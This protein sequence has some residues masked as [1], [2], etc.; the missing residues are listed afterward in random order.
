MSHKVRI[1]YRKQRR[2]W[3]GEYWLN[4]KRYAKGF[5]NK[6]EAQRWRLYMLH[7]LNYEEWQGTPGL[8]WNIFTKLY[9]DHKDS[10]DIA[11]ATRW[12]IVNSLKLFALHVGQL[13]SNLINQGHIE[14]FIRKRKKEVENRTVNKDLEA[15]RALYNWALDNHYVH[16]GIKFHMLKTIKKQFRPPTLEQLSELFRLAKEYPPLHLRMV[17]ALTTGL[18]RSAIERIGLNEKDEYHIDLENNIIV[19]LEIKT[20]QQLCKSLGP[21]VMN[22][23]HKYINELPARSKKLFPRRWDSRNGAR[24]YWEDIRVRA[25]LPKM[26]FHNLR[27][28]SVSY[29]AD[30]GESAAVLQKHISHSS[31]STTQ[32][33]IG[34]GKVTQ[35]RITQKMDELMMEIV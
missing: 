34:I 1:W 28:L 10:Q 29:L 15:L 27:N 12:G 23:I 9:L 35:D 2:K 14:Q 6:A 25:G 21:N 5:K 24:K 33:Y 30:K 26:T 22:L 20:K 4:K 17:L 31:F 11:P 8:E 18:R 16:P 13:Q 7:K 32:G 19:T 3:Y